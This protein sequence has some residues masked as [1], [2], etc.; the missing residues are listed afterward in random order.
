MDS[1][2]ARPTVHAEFTG[3][4]DCNTHA[5]I[6]ATGLTVFLKSYL[7]L[8][9]LS[10][11]PLYQVFPQPTQFLPELVSSRDMASPHLSSTWGTCVLPLLWRSVSVLQH[12]QL[13]QSLLLGQ[14]WCST[15]SLTPQ[16]QSLLLFAT[17]E[18]LNSKDW[19]CCW[20]Q[21]YEWVSAVIH[22]Q[23]PRYIFPQG[24]NTSTFVCESE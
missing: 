11:A 5:I 18:R 23:H 10:K 6:Q 16:M 12:S 15:S 22:S 7:L 2:L 21:G 24:V 4:K 13:H 9:R 20:S 3:S 14:Q 1:P 19:S 8:S 17:S